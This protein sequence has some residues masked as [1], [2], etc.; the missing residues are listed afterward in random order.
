MSYSKHARH[1]RFG[2]FRK[3]GSNF[4]KFLKTQATRLTSSATGTTVALVEDTEAGK[5][6]PSFTSTAHG[7]SNGEGPYVLTAAT[8]LPTGYTAGKHVWVRRVDANTVAL[9]SS[10]EDAVKGTRLLTFGTAGVGALTLTKPLDEASVF[11]ALKRQSARR[12]RAA[13]DVDALA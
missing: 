9:A 12:V 2:R 3:A 1:S 5:W 7:I 4:K 13:T 6:G 11:V 8:T 10:R